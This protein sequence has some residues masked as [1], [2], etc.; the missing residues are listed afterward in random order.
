[1]QID[2]VEQVDDDDEDGEEAVGAAKKGKGTAVVKAVK[3]KAARKAP[4]K[5]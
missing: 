4:A 3:P 5:K 1:M 2:D